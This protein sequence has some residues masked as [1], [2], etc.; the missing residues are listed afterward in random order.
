[1]EGRP[2]YCMLLYPQLLCWLQ[3]PTHIR[4][5][6]TQHP[7]M[8]SFEHLHIISALSSFVDQ[9]FVHS[10]EARGSLLR[11]ALKAASMPTG[12]DLQEHLQCLQPYGPLHVPALLVIEAETFPLNDW[13]AQLFHSVEVAQTLQPGH[14]KQYMRYTQQGEFEESH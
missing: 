2:V 12:T 13:M 8:K 5:F 7:S 6:Y 10:L 3:K 9:T 4:P 14:L 11:C 1:M